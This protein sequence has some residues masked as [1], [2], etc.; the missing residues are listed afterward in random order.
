MSVGA[1]VTSEASTRAAADG[2]TALQISALQTSVG[3]NATN[4]STET[5]ARTT[6]DTSLGSRIDSLTATVNGNVAAITNEATTRAAADSALATQTQTLSSQVLAPPNLQSNGNFENGLTGYGGNVGSFTVQPGSSGG[7]GN[8]VYSFA[9]GT[10]VLTPPSISVFPSS[11][12]T[13]SYDV[14]AY[15]NS[16][17]AGDVRIDVQDSAGGGWSASG[18]TY[19]YTSGHNFSATTRQTFQF[20]TGSNVNS[21]YLRLIGE[22]LSNVSIWGFRQ[23]SVVL[24]AYPALPYNT[25]GTVQTLASTVQVQASTLATL[26]QVYGSYGVRVEADGSG[27]VIWTGLTLYAA[28]GAV[29]YSGVAIDADQLVIRKPGKAGVA[30]FLFDTTTGTAYLQNV[31]IQGNLVVGGSITTAQL[32]AG[33][34]SGSFFFY[35]D[36]SANPIDIGYGTVTP[37][38]TSPMTGTGG[39]ASG[40]TASGSGGS[41]KVGRGPVQ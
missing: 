26:Q 28:S 25:A 6:A 1:S 7:W 23:I 33:A 4:I 15:W 13:V 34:V 39:G 36:Y 10:A 3:S 29:N 2:A 16:G 11:T 30:P 17:G 19:L 32:A 38:A 40:G 37:A 8:Y 35:N 41:G 21:I 9:N 22:G 12:Y 14:V 20:T 27:G 31:S 24:G 5:T 18:P